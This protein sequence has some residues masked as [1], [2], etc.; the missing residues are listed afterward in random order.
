M[1][2]AARQELRGRFEAA[3]GEADAATLEQLRADG[4]EAADFLASAVV[5]SPLDAAGRAS[6]AAVAGAQ[7][8]PVLPGMDLPREDKKARRRD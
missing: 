4:L 5:G 1:L 2:A 3:R 8:E 6:V 7:V